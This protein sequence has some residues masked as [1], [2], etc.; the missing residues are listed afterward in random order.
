MSLGYTKYCNWHNPRKTAFRRFDKKIREMD[1][2]IE[3][4]IIKTDLEIDQCWDVAFLLR[5]HLKRDK[6]VTMVTEMMHNERYFIAGIYKNDKFAAFAGCRFMT[7]LHT[8]NI[9]YIDDLC[10]LDAYR[11][12]GFASRLI[13]YVREIAKMNQLDALVLDTDFTNSGAQ[14]VYLKSGFQLAALHL[15][16]DLRGN[17][18]K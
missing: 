14:K 7:S 13:A 15:A 2:Q 11:G 1:D 16:A 4:R 6:W 5:P 12:K 3:V 8:G 18:E 17:G 10:T 9:I